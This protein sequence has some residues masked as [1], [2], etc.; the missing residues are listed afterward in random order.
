MTN[1]NV[2][3]DGTTT[4]MTEFG[5]INHPTGIATFPDINSGSLRLLGYPSSSNS[6]T[7]KVFLVR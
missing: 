4:Y 2:I 6:T 1:I 5:T 3:H 7:F